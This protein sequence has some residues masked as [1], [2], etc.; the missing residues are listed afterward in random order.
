MISREIEVRFEIRESE[1]T[2]NSSSRGK[3]DVSYDL[4]VQ[5]AMS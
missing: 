3:S 2:D 1:I 4:C 5:H